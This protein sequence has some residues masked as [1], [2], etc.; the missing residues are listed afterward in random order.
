MGVNTCV[1]ITDAERIRVLFVEDEF[2]IGSG[3][4]NRSRNKDLLSTA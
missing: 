2:F 3:L 4:Q 1:N